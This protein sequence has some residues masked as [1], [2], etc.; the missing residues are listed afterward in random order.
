MS[1]PTSRPARP[2]PAPARTPGR[3]ILDANCRDMPHFTDLPA[4]QAKP[5]CKTCP[6]RRPCY[7]QGLAE[8]IEHQHLD[9]SDAQ[10]VYAG[11]TLYELITFAATCHTEAIA[12]I[13]GQT[14]P[15]KPLLK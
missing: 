15:D 10:H 14:P 5:I 12:Q 6:V 8:A 3:W 2:H 11:Q 1:D 9:P 7:L 4:D 13:T